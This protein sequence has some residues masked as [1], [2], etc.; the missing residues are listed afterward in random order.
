ME[1]IRNAFT[2][3]EVEPP[4]STFRVSEAAVHRTIGA[5]MNKLKH[6]PHEIETVAAEAEHVVSNDAKEIGNRAR[7]TMPSQSGHNNDEDEDEG[8]MSDRSA[9][10]QPDASTSAITD[11]TK[12]TKSPKLKI[13]P[14]PVGKGRRRSSMR[15]GMFGRAHLLQQKQPESSSVFEDSDGEDDRGRREF[16]IAE[17]RDGLGSRGSGRSLRLDLM[18]GIDTGREES[19]ARSIRFLDEVV[20]E[21]NRSGANTPRL[22]ILHDSFTGLPHQGSIDDV[23]SPKNKVTFDLS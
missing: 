22:S 11:G 1:V 17:P 20:D 10:R 18:R 8:W 7:R 13:L 14:K 5:Y 16:A 2:A 6:V 4:S 15:K 3:S 12:R 21:E 9:N 19:P 23:D